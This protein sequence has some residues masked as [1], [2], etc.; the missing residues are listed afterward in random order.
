MVRF[1]ID[2]ILHDIEVVPVAV[3]G[4]ITSRIKVLARMDIAERRRPQD[5]RIKTQRGEREVELRVSSMPTA[6]GEKIVVR[7]FDPSVLAADLQDLGFSIA[8]NARATRSWITAP[9]GLDA[10]DGP[11]GLG[12]DDHA[13][14]DAALPVRPEINITTVEDP[15]EMV[16]P[17]FCQVQVKPQ[18]EVSFSSALRSILRQDPDI[19]MVGEIRDAE[20]AQDGGAVGADRTP[21]LLDGAHARRGRRRSPG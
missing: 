2:G 4:A 7:V 8:E 20:T 9:S 6:Y 1:R 21:G 10:G 11:T 19:I 13:L 12:Q 5:G 15:I 17:R 14:L 3:H 16:D 18:I